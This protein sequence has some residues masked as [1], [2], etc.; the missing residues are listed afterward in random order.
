MCTTRSWVQILSSHN[1]SV[2]NLHDVSI[3]MIV[4][5]KRLRAETRDRL[6]WDVC[7][8]CED[9]DHSCFARGSCGEGVALTSNGCKEHVL[10]RCF[11]LAQR[12]WDSNERAYEGDWSTSISSTIWKT[13]FTKFRNDGIKDCIF[14]TTNVDLLLARYFYPSHKFWVETLGYYFLLL[15]WR[16]QYDASIWSLI[17]EKWY[18]VY[19][20]IKPWQYESTIYPRITP[21]RCVCV[22]WWEGDR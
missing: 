12:K 17:L 5:S 2:M 10:A 7:A 15:S 14:E 20:G 8:G 18:K 13:W 4:T 22:C 9:D 21:S 1:V 6:Q 11:A 16:H 3:V 19:Q